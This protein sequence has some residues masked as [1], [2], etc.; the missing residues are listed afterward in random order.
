[1]TATEQ[2]LRL[3]QIAAQAAEDKLATDIAAFDVSDRLPLVDVFLLAS[4]PN[5]R[6]VQAIVDHVEER[7]R[8]AGVKPLRREG[9]Q[10]GRWILLDFGDLVVHIQHEEDRLYYQ[11]E[12]LWRDCPPVPLRLGPRQADPA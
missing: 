11:L 12:R 4:A 10:K 8:E 3:T 9:E 6:Q 1:M 5:D 7:L 2:A